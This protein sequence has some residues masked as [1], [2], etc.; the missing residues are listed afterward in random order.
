PDAPGF[1]E[2]NIL[3]RKIARWVED[4][5][6][7]IGLREPDLSLPR[8]ARNW[9]PLVAIA[10]DAGPEWKERALLAMQMAQREVAPP[11]LE[12]LLSDIHEILDPRCDRIAS[13]ELAQLLGE[14]E[15]R[16]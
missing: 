12:L 11:T 15:G 2:F 13:A 16:P 10:A 14:K 5:F 8:A 1:T 7:D 6:G 4:E 3:G 9:L